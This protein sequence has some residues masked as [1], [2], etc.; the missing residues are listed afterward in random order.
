LALSLFSE[1]LTGFSARKKAGKAA[2][3][4]RAS[5]RAREEKLEFR[6]QLK[7]AR[8]SKIKEAI[9]QQTEWYG[10]KSPS[11]LLHSLVY[12]FSSSFSSGSLFPSF[13][14]CL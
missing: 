10:S 14:F 2:A 1:Y 11:F 9:D 3:L 5:Q 4:E 6:R 7:D 13:V 12:T 8:L